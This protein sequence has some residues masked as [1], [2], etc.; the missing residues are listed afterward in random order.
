MGLRRAVESRNG[1]GS[2]TMGNRATR[3][4]SIH[5]FLSIWKNIMHILANRKTYL[6]IVRSNLSLSQFPQQGRRRSIA[7]VTTFTH[8]N[9]DSLSHGG[10][11]VLLSLAKREFF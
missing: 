10:R 3:L 11:K 6:I 5:P 2:L 8:Q 4:P 1:S 7:T 9:R